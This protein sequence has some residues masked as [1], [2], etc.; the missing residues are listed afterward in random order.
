M[1]VQRRKLS[2]CIHSPAPSQV[3]TCNSAHTLGSPAP[4]CW[5]EAA[6]QHLLVTPLVLLCFRGVTIGHSRPYWT[7]WWD[8]ETSQYLRFQSLYKKEKEK[9]RGGERKAESRWR[10]GAQF[11]LVLFWKGFFFFPELKLVAFS[12]QPCLYDADTL[13]INDVPSGSEK[14]SS[15]P[16]I[17]VSPQGTRAFF[18]TDP[19]IS[20]EKIQVVEHIWPYSQWQQQVWFQGVSFTSLVF[21]PQNLKGHSLISASVPQ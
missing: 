3:P 6:L 15:D 19:L 12:L 9:K 2:A 16:Q 20:H 21:Q 4:C 11:G 13:M 5:G 17:L 10:K 14:F 8:L 7:L 18:K 1:E